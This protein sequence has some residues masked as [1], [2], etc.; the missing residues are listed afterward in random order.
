MT[1][2]YNLVYPNSRPCVGFVDST[3]H[4]LRLI[5]AA[6]EGVILRIICCL[7]DTERKELVIS[8]TVFVFAVEESEIKRWTDSHRWSPSRIIGNF[9]VRWRFSFQVLYSR[10]EN[11]SF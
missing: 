10:V 11:E 1:I 9:L 8:G 4:A 3:V 6:R 2:N 7:N 5:L